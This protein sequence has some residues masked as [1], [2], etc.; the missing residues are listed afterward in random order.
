MTS[1]GK[2]VT[3]FLHGFLCRSE[4]LTI[5]Q[6]QRFFYSLSSGGVITTD[7]ETAQGWLTREKC[8]LE[9]A[10]FFVSIFVFN[11]FRFTRKRAAYVL[12][13]VPFSWQTRKLRLTR[14]LW[15]SV[16]AKYV[17]FLP[18]KIRLRVPLHVDGTDGRGAN[19]R[20]V[21]PTVPPLLHTLHTS[22]RTRTER[23]TSTNSSSSHHTA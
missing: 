9:T 16:D 3:H 19:S 14:Y 8:R 22:F 4:L 6:Q 23:D 2:K 13:S 1:D 15:D 20:A 12:T 11:F 10:A 5:T 17:C 18:G 7:P 21:F